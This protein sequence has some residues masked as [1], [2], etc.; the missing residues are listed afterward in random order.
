[1]GMV[2]KQARRRFVTVRLDDDVA[3]DLIGDVAHAVCIGAF[4]FAERAALV[5]DDALVPFL[6]FAPS[7]H[8]RDFA[9]LARRFVKRLPF[10]EGGGR[11]CIKRHEFHDGF[12]CCFAA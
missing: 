8:A 12:P 10:G 1:M 7:F 5:D 11:S 6:P 9:F 2:L 3:G 4:G